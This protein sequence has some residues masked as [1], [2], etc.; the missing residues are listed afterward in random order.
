VLVALLVIV[1][2]AVVV[3]GLGVARVETK[4]APLLA[5]RRVLAAAVSFPGSQ[6]TLAWPAQGEAAVSVEG[7]GTLGS[8][9]GSSPVPIA[10]LAKMMTAYLTLRQ[11]PLALGAAGFHL[12]VTPAD[13]ADDDARVAE[14]QSTLPV[15]D[16]EV[17]DEYQILE[18]L[19]IPSANNVAAMVAD[20]DAG[21]QAA[22]VARMNAE[23]KTLGMDQTDYTDPSGF[24]ST[25]VSVAADQ[26]R[27]AAVVMSE[28]VLARI[29][30]QRSVTL[31]VAGKMSNYDALVG[32]D[33]FTGIKTGS[34]SQAG[35][36]FAFSDHRSIDGHQ[37]TLIGVVLGQDRGRSAT[38]TIV[39]AA[40]DAARKLADS[41]TAAL[42]VAA[43]VA[44]GTPV[45]DVSNAAGDRVVATT[46]SA[47]DEL[48]WGGLRLR[49]QVRP[50]PPVRHLGAGRRVATVGVRG[51]LPATAAAVATSS[52]PALSFT[53]RARHLL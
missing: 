7:V 43:V 33:G 31:P 20:Y 41:A 28:P 35:G 4:A 32:T 15:D 50:A 24:A 42:R 16:G 1:V 45:V 23:A 13:V 25:T 40:L 19:L 38:D 9:G 51:Y 30:A 6:P 34:D 26:L 3:A 11:H 48:G 2:V 44:A 27:L 14:G 18:A 36:C 10:S 47:L 5:T 39:P 17:L 21:S 12:T 37:V 22:F 49:V 46:S 29:V 53:W 52:M 8:A